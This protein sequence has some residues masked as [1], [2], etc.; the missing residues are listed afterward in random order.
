MYTYTSYYNIAPS[1][2]S[3]YISRKESSVNTRLGTEKHQL[4]MPPIRKDCFNIFLRRSFIHAAPCEW[5]KFSEHIRTS[6]FPNF[7][8]SVKQCYLHSNVYA[9]CKQQY[10]YIIIISVIITVNYCKCI[11]LLYSPLNSYLHIHWI[12]DFK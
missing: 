2:E 12:L 3:A 5:N 9:D 8:K 7:R 10:L 4:M 6:N 11:L 1:Y